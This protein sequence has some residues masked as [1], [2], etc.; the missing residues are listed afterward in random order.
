MLL[1][2]DA[3][4]A[5]LMAAGAGPFNY[6]HN[7]NPLDANATYCSAPGTINSWTWTNRIDNTYV[8]WPSTIRPEKKG[9]NLGILLQEQA[10]RNYRLEDYMMYLSNVKNIPVGISPSKS[11]VAVGSEGLA[12]KPPTDVAVSE[13]N[14]TCKLEF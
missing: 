3:A 9:T 1:A 10:I 14:F 11:F 13:R 4:T 5:V 12:I 6:S 8:T 2:T 7:Y